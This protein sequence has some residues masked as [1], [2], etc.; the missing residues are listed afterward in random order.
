V[1]YCLFAV[2]TLQNACR[3]CILQHVSKTQI[4]ALPIPMQMKEYLQYEAS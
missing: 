4:D 1:H 2:A 3:D